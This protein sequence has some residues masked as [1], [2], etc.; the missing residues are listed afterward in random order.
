MRFLLLLL[1]AAL[2]SVSAQDYQ[3]FA[4]GY[5]GQDN[6]YENYAMKQAEKADGGG[7]NGWGKTIGVFGLS[8]LAGAKFHSSRLTKKMKSKHMKEQKTLYT[9]YYN[10]VYKLEEQKQEQQKVIE[11]LQ[12]ALG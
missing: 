4:D 9:Q 11:Q 2:V 8:Y 12:T 3:D 5:E 1:V 10:D 7:G 6:L